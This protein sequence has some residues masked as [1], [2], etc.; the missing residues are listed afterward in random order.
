M[1]KEEWSSASEEDREKYI[2]SFVERMVDRCE[3][4]MKPDRDRW[5]LAGDVFAGKQP[6]SADRAA[7]PWMSTPF[8]HEMSASCRRMAAGLQNLIFERKD[9]FGLEYVNERD[10]EFRRV[11]EK[12][13]RHYIESINFENSTYEFLLIGGVYGI[14]CRK[15]VAVPSLEWEPEVVVTQLD[16]QEREERSKLKKDVVGAAKFELPADPSEMEGRIVTALDELL[17]EAGPK[18]KRELKPTRRLKVKFA[19]SFPNLFN[20]FFDPDARNINESAYFIERHF[21]KYYELLPLAQSGVIS[22]AKLKTLKNQPYNSVAATGANF[23]SSDTGQKL[24][25]RD[26]FENP[27]TSLP[28]LEVLE[29]FGPLLDKAGDIIEENRH[30]LVGNR[31]VLLKSRQNGYFSQK[32][33]YHFAV[34]S[35]I[36]FKPVGQGVAD[37]AIEHNLLINDLFGLWLDM[38]KLAVYSPKTFDSGKLNDPRQV[39]G[40]LKPGQLIDVMG[41]G[42]E[43][44][45]KDIPVNVNGVGGPLFQ[46]IEALRLSGEK[47]SGVDTNSANPASRARISAAE[48]QSNAGRA[49]ESFLALA[50]EVDANYI[51]PTITTLFEYALQFGFEDDVLSDL[52]ADGILTQSEFELIKQIPRVARYNE[53]KRG[54][55]IKI[56]G[57]RERLE[58]DEFL[59]KTNELLSI[60]TRIPPNVVNVKWQ[61]ILKQLLE[62]LNFDTDEILPQNTPQDKAREE[63]ALLTR[64]GNQQISI[65]EL[66]DHV[67]E[68]PVHYEAALSAPA[69]GLL[70][71]IMGHIQAS[72]GNF[73]PPPPQLAQMLG[74]PPQ[75][76][77]NEGGL[78]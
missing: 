62:T 61:A 20:L 17:G 51:I 8:L 27:S 50:R 6:A 45:F 74:L 57:F 30:F 77:M 33:P 38:M 54:C 23:L 1:L 46:T 71:H 65:G 22:E 49:S 64:E 9:F 15:L 2:C 40:Y 24:G 60:I 76:E 43:Q 4:E 55:R 18:F 12:I 53:I 44:I 78:H 21:P 47:G 39:E 41:D 59:A 34:F 35:K 10:E 26:Q 37:N 66:D 32:A 63:N 7:H 58:R 75:N 14:A 5:M 28:V 48:I 31:K 13:T 67:A 11:I 36:P 25:Q 70:Q 16:K 3:L 29:Y 42:G 52:V 73:P 56:K 68:L 69:P 19:L 72:G